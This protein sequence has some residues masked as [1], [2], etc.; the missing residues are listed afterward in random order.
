MLSELIEEFIDLK[1]A[2]EPNSSQWRSIDE[3]AFCRNA[4]YE[5]LD[6]LRSQ[7][8]AIAADREKNK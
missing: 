2:G 6:E 7:I 3:D 4:Y 5:R 1:I 8:D